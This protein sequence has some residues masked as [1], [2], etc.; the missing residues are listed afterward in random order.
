MTNDSDKIENAQFFVIDM[1]DFE[2]IVYKSGES[3]PLLSRRR[4]ETSWVPWH[5][6]DMLPPDSPFTLCAM[7][8]KIRT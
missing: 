4:C 2:D 8:L 7:R 5:A 1:H 6:E 3:T